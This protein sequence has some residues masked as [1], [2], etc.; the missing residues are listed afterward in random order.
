MQ[1]TFSQGPQVFELKEH[2]TFF[3]RVPMMLEQKLVDSWSNLQNYIF[4]PPLCE[5]SAVW[6]VGGGESCLRSLGDQHL[7]EC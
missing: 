1:I 2:G 6:C 5:L 4:I 3:L 7:A